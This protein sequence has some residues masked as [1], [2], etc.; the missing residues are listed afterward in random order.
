MQYKRALELDGD[1]VPAL[2]GMASVE[3]HIYR[4]IDPTPTRLALAERFAQRALA[5]DPRLPRALVATGEVFAVQFDYR[6]AAERFRDATRLEPE[7]SWNWDMLSWALGYTRPP[8]ARGAEQAAREALRLQPRFVRAYYH[9]GRALGIQGRY[10]EAVAAM[11]H[12][13]E[14][15]PDSGIARYGL[16]ELHLAQ[17]NFDA[18]LEQ[19]HGDTELKSSA[20]GLV[21]MAAV[22]AARNETG[23]AL[24]ALEQALLRGY[25]DLAAIDANPHFL[26]LRS[27]V[28]FQELRQR[29]SRSN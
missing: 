22:H 18:A 21:L 3:A 9:L 4:N 5:L 11:G 2:A 28:R 29:A 10:E 15:A 20:I 12:V 8:D 23:P 24:E 19:M 7:E 16:A 17:G 13:L 1:F 6:R 27:E 25:R 14:A 26:R